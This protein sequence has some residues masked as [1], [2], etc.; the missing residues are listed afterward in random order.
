MN[1]RRLTP[2][3]TLSQ[4]PFCLRDMLRRSANREARRQR[5]RAFFR[6]FFGLDRKGTGPRNGRLG[7][8][9][10]VESNLQLR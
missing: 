4:V 8:G 2:T 9:E 7:T 1:V 3:L 6:Q 5:N 10:M